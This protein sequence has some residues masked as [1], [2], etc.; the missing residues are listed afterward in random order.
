MTEAFRRVMETKQELGPVNKFM[1]QEPIKPGEAL[2]QKVVITDRYQLTA[3]G[4]YTVTMRSL[5]LYVSEL[6]VNSNMVTITVAP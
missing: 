6:E 3:P 1:V 4:K 5:D 2:T